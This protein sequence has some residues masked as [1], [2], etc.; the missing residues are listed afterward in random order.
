MRHFDDYEEGGFDAAGL[1]V[2]RLQRQGK[3]AVVV[4]WVDDELRVAQV[5]GVIGVADVLR[6]DAPAVVKRLKEV[7][8]ERVVM[9][10]GDHEEV[11][12]AIAAEAGVDAF[13]AGL[14][15][16]DKLRIIKEEEAAYGPIA[17]VGDGV[18]DAPAL[19]AATIGM[20]MG[21]AGTDVALETAD[22]VLMSDDL[23]RIPYAIGLSRQTRRTLSAEPG[24]RPRRHRHPRRRRPRRSAWPSPSASSATRAAR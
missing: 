12:A 22:V 15:P 23:T 20:A 14:L 2:S 17:M 11:A 19:A 4:A 16:E 21:A 24:L 3:T 9:L 18:N 10:T 1:T 5:A 13:H 7:G 6:P 8:V